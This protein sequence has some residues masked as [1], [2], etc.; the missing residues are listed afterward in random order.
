M[1]TV[2]VQ[3]LGGPL[4][5]LAVYIILDDTYLKVSTNA[6]D[7][8]AVTFYHVPA[9]TEITNLRQ[10]EIEGEIW[11]IFFEIALRLSRMEAAVAT[12]RHKGIHVALAPV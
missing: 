10:I 9:S 4:N 8:I 6:R 12:I 3:H 2:Y 7:S 11:R 1:K 5:E